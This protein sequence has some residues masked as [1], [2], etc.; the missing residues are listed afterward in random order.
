[1]EPSHAIDKRIIDD[2]GRLHV[3][4]CTLSLA[5]VSPYLG[6]EI[7]GWDSLGL[8]PD[9]V[10]RL[11]RTP[12][13]LQAMAA[14]AAGSI[15]LTDD[16]I[17]VSAD[18]PQKDRVAGAV[19]NLRAVDGGRRLV[20]DLSV[21]TGDS[22]D[23]VQN[24][25]KRELSCAYRYS[26][27]MIPATRDGVLVDGEMLPCDGNVLNHVAL[28]AKGRAGPQ[29][30]VADTGA[31]VMK[32]PKIFD[33]LSQILS[34]LAKPEQLTALDAALDEE[35]EPKAADEFPPKK[36]DDKDDD[37]AAEDKRATHAKGAADADI[38]AAAAKAT[39]GMVTRD[40]AQ[41][42]ANDAAQSVIATF[43]AREAVAPKV[44]VVNTLDRAEAIYRFAM[45]KCGIEH[46]DIPADAL[47][48]TW[49]AIQKGAPAVAAD[50]A[51]KGTSNVH[52]LFP[53]HI[54]KG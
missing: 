37:K 41:K 49:A 13:L 46:K 5:Q 15:P 18:S 48:A 33:A 42:M 51:A 43:K 47:A 2:D 22:I 38:A 1:M 3:P 50:S 14:S 19:N 40:E 31:R 34:T 16:H 8:I 9:K 27:R 53:T 39:E 6:R 11:Y 10:Y 44:G 23:R 45:D 24:E 4:D 36:D 7:P 52:D 25:S 28:V 29:A 21:W 17:I 26:V 54:R 35:L 20:G 32:R 12:E 30:T